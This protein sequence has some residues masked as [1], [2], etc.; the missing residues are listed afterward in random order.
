MPTGTTCSPGSPPGATRAPTM[1]RGTV[2]FLA[3]AVLLAHTLA[4]YQTP[5]GEFGPPYEVAHAAYRLGRNAVFEGLP[6]WNPRSPWAEAP[7]R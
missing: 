1:N 5:E 6:L 3:L 4:I 7:T 2:I